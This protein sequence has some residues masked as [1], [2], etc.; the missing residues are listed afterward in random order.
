MKDTP[1][2]IE[3][4]YKA[5]LKGKSNEERLKMGCS[6]FKLASSFMI[7]SLIDKGI[8]SDELKKHL[9]IKIYGNDIDEEIRNRIMARL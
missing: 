6:M 8:R 5:M 3:Q 9:F 2:A 7:S 1:E 4:R